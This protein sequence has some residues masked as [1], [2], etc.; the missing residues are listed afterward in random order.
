MKTRSVSAMGTLFNFYSGNRGEKLD[1]H[2][3]DE[4]HLTVV[5][6]GRATVANRESSIP[7]SPE[8]DPVLFR[9]GSEHMLVIEEDD[10]AFINIFSQ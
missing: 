6:R 3:H 7:L 1:W 5:T 9:A 10:T 4:D 2:K 8:D